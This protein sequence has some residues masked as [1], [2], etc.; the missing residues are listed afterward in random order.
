MPL[1][2]QNLIASK[3]TAMTSSQQYVDG[4]SSSSMPPTYETYRLKP[5]GGP[6][7]IMVKRVFAS[8]KFVEVDKE[9]FLSNYHSQF[10]GDFE[11]FGMV[12]DGNNTSLF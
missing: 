11:W 3:S 2:S 9:T 8:Y 4:L 6:K 10:S 12:D 5:D 7:Y 1:L